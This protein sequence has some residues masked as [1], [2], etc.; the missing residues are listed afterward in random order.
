[1]SKYKKTELVIDP[2]VIDIPKEEV[3]VTD[4]PRNKLLFKKRHR[5]DEE[6]EAYG[7]ERK[8]EDVFLDSL[9][10]RPRLPDVPEEN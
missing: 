2:S 8:P 10:G 4:F 7:R 3:R 1:V 5:L 9:D 6:E